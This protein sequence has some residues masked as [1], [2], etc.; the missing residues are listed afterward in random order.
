[1]EMANFDPRGSKFPERISM[2]L[3]MYN[4]VGGITTHANPHDIVT[5]CVV[6]A[7]TWLV[8]CF[9]FLVYLFMAALRS[10]CRHHI[11]QLWFLS[12]FLLISFFLAYSQRSQ[13]G[14][15]PYFHTWCG[16]NANLECRSGLCCMRLAEN[17]G[18]KNRQKIAICTP[19]HNFVGLYPSN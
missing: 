11:L 6:P 12:I 4:Y 5:T 13:I 16:L 17:T 2:K 18:R 8:T 15:L 10:S 7:N 3:E 9:G 1:M 14:C 19:S